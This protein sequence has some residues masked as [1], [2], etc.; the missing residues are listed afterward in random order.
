MAEAY[1]EGLYS[2]G[3][4]EEGCTTQGTAPGAPD[5]GLFGQPA[6]IAYPTLIGLAIIIGTIT[7]LISRKL[8][9]RKK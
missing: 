8:R 2:C 5:T 6:Y 1:G 3:Q 7:F 4:F 9:G